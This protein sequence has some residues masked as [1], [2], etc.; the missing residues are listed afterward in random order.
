M[1]IVG[2]DA[3]WA[4][5]ERRRG[6][7][8]PSSSFMSFYNFWS[9]YGGVE[10]DLATSQ[11]WAAASTETA[12]FARANCPVC[13]QS[14]SYRLTW[15]VCVHCQACVHHTCLQPPKDYWVDASDVVCLDCAEGDD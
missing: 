15:T 3:I 12:P 13:S 8:K 14:L 9:P 2:Q 7:E 4:E 1:H 6:A 10:I 11:L 5:L